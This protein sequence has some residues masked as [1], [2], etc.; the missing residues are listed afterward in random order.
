MSVQNGE[1]NTF[2][3]TSRG[4]QIFHQEKFPSKMH[5]R[6]KNQGN[7]TRYAKE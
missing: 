4:E 7:G 3:E 6:E 5:S 2:T 1:K